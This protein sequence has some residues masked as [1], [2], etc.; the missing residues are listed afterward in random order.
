[1][2]V[3]KDTAAVVQEYE[4]RIALAIQIYG[5][6]PECGGEIT[7][8]PQNTSV[9]QDKSL[10]DTSLIRKAAYRWSHSGVITTNPSYNPRQ[11]GAPIFVPTGGLRRKR[12]LRPNQIRKLVGLLGPG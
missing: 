4:T 8:M 1:M 2:M 11:Y 9:P 10:T 6:T 5:A 7:T 3:G 12:V